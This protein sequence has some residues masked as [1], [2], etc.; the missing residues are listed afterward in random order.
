MSRSC[1]VSITGGSRAVYSYRDCGTLT[2]AVILRCSLF[3]SSAASDGAGDP[4]LIDMWVLVTVLPCRC[5]IALTWVAHILS[6]LLVNHLIFFL[7]KLEGITN[8]LMKL[9]LE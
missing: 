9:T 2:T 3:S 4:V 7:E 6:F 8:F 1:G 5:A